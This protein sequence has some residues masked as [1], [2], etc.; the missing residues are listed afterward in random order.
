MSAKP[1]SGGPEASPGFHLWH[2][3]LA[4]KSAVAKALEPHGLTPTQFFLLGA[5]GWHLKTRGEPPTQAL[6]ARAAGLDPM[7]TSQVL[8]AL[9]KARLI[10]RRD[11]PSD[12]RSWRLELPP[13]GRA[14]LVAAAAAVREADLAVFGP[15]GSEREALVAAVRAVRARVEAPTGEDQADHAPHRATGAP[16][17]TRAT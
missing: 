14:R 13:E 8:R 7:T 10:E 11:D 4:W 6:A 17:R 16:R 9:E 3:S 1:S 15:P 2:A 12:A 5:V